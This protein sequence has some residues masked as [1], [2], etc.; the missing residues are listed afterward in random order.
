MKINDVENKLN[1]QTVCSVHITF[2]VGKSD[3]VWYVILIL[4]IIFLK[5]M[6]HTLYAYC[7]VV[8]H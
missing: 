3:R 2:N 1:P 6:G 4:W 5:E 7:R 8:S